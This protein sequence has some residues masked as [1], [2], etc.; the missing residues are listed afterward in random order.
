MS[1]RPRIALL[2]LQGGGG[3]YGGGAGPGCAAGAAGQGGGGGGS[4]FFDPAFA[5]PAG[6]NAYSL[7]SSSPSILISYVPL[8]PSGNPSGRR[9]R[10]ARAVARLTRCQY[11]D[12]TQVRP[13]RG[14]S[15][16]ILQRM[17]CFRARFARRV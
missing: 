1:V 10:I 12:Q 13:V 17:S 3:L 8:V 7:A 6:G 2:T 14:I 4:S 5:T 15:L 9:R 11:G 16:L